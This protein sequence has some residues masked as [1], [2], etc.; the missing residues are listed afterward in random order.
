MFTFE[1][2]RGRYFKQPVVINGLPFYQFVE[3]DASGGILQ[4]FE[5]PNLKQISGGHVSGEH[6]I[7][8]NP[9]ENHYDHLSGAS[10]WKEYPF[11]E[12]RP[13]ESKYSISGASLAIMANWANPASFA[14]V[15]SK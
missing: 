5:K 15:S 4:V 12:G 13:Y 3:M 7:V 8:D 9:I 6:V 14:I 10:I 2:K 1:K 11:K